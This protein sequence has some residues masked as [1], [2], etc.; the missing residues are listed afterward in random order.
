MINF[1]DTDFNLILMFNR[2]LMNW[3]I[4]IL[5]ALMKNGLN[6]KDISEMMKG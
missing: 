4:E 2:F 1:Q 6:L 3:I 5:M